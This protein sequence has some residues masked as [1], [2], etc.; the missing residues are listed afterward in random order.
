MKPKAFLKHFSSPSI[1][2]CAWLVYPTSVPAQNTEKAAPD[3]HALL[4]EADRLFIERKSG[5]YHLEGMVESLHQNKQLRSDKVL[6]L[7][8]EKNLY[9]RGNVVLVMEDGTA[10]FSD[11]L[12]LNQDFSTGTAREF[13]ARLANEGKLG[14]RTVRYQ[15]EGVS[16]LEKA[17]Y[18]ACKV[19]EGKTGKK[20]TWILK[21]QQVRRDKKD[22]MIYYRNA[23]LEFLGIPVLYTPYFA[24]AD[25]TSER[26]SGF[27]P[28]DLGY[29]KRT[30]FTFALPYYKTL[31]PSQDITFT[32]RL[33]SKVN[34]LLSINYRKRFY[35]GQMNIKL[36]LGYDQNFDNEGKKFGRKKFRGSL[37]SDGLFNLNSQWSWGYGIQ[38]VSDNNYLERYNLDM[39]VFSSLPFQPESRQLLNQF[40][41]RG[42]SENFF[43]RGAALQYNSLL[44]TVSDRTLPIIAPLIEFHKSFTPPILGGQGQASFQ[45]AVL[46]RLNGQ[47]YARASLGLSWTRDFITPQGVVIEPFIKT[48]A[49][50]YA[51]GDRPKSDPTVK[52]FS[53][54]LAFTGVETR[55]PFFR[56]GRSVDW[57]FEPVGQF[58]Y[59]FGKD[60]LIS[61]GKGGYIF[62]HLSREENAT[63]DLSATNLFRADK[64][65]GFDRFDSAPRLNL[66]AR[67]TAYWGPVG[68]FSVFA[69]QSFSFRKPK[70]YL[71]SSGLSEKQSDYV[72]S[73]E[74]QFNKAF[75]AYARA[76]FNHTS[77]EVNRFELGTQFQ[78]S[79]V[80][81][82]LRY[83]KFGQS[84]SRIGPQEEAQGNITLKL[85]DNWSVGYGNLYDF[86][87]GTSRNHTFKL[88]YTDECTEIQF[89]YVRDGTS[90]QIKDGGVTRTIGPSESFKVRFVLFTLG[91]INYN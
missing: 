17:S 74:V 59:T 88:A 52:N 45:S 89:L 70:A 69:G 10:Q 20:P 29:A 56:H 60:D 82:G 13:S 27:L 16:S 49:D 37:F 44:G 34:P 75:S 3:T 8:E 62:K 64:F 79:K 54:L 6:Y 30:G 32:P 80:Q 66:G 9:A 65:P 11:D 83:S 86:D 67:A 72:V 21:A 35:S 73:T 5:R 25:P 14:A 77:L 41:L 40:F 4:F 42:Q 78:I 61:D 23:K 53:R 55:W 12:K 15:K 22:Q 46:T 36:G 31:S 47:D 1:L 43:F 24:H 85:T 71:P 81:L 63:L 50:V 2:A 26:H 51:F 33:M 90:Y 7:P 39:P 19:C 76:R 58:V 28:P 68:R 87:V 18:T 84:Y 48:R 57:V 91:G 38:Q